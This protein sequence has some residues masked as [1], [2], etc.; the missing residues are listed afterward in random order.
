MRAINLR[1]FLGILLV[2]TFAALTVAQ[3]FGVA[4]NNAVGGGFCPPQD[5]ILPCRCTANG[6]EIQIW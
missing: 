2:G 4:D 3:P 6:E 1:Q 5:A